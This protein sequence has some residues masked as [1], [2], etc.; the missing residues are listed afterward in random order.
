MKGIAIPLI[1]AGV[2]LPLPVLAL[3]LESGGGPGEFLLLLAVA[4]LC[5]LLWW[6][7]Y[8]WRRASDE[9]TRQ[10][11]ARARLFEILAGAPDGHYRWDLD[12]DGQPI[13]ERCSRRL[14][15]LLDLFGGVG[16]SFTNVLDSFPP[17]AAEK[18]AAA[19][20]ALRA[21]GRGFELELPL[22][23]ASRR[24]LVL[25]GR[26]A[27]E[28]GRAL[29][30]VVWIR[31]VTERS[32]VLDRLALESQTLLNGRDQLRAVFDMLPVPVWIR[33]DDLALRGCNL[34]YA[35]A[36]DA[37][38]PEEAVEQGRELAPAGMVREAR[39]LAARARAAGASRSES[40]HLVMEGA[41]RMAEVI[42]TPLM[43]GGAD[44]LL[45][46]GISIDR[47]RQ[48]EA[49]ALVDRHAVAHAE[50]LENLGTAIAIFAADTRLSFFNTAF[51]KL[52]GLKDEWGETKP[53]YGEVLDFWRET[54]RLPEVADFRDF[55][56]EETRRFTSL[57]EPREDLLHLP[58]ER[59]LRRVISPHP[60]GGLIFTYED[61]TDALALK[62]SYTTS[63]A[64]HGETLDN[65]HEGVAVFG[66]DGRLRLSNPAYGRIWKLESEFL[67][68]H[69]H[70]GELV[71]R[72]RGFFLSATDWSEARNELA[73]LFTSRQGHRGRIERSD[74]SHLDYA[75]LPLPDGSVLTTWLD[76]SD[77]VRVEIALRERNEALAAADKLKSEFLASVS[78]EVR[79]P[80]TTI[81]GH[82]DILASGGCGALNNRQTDYANGITAAG[83]HLEQVFSDIL[84]L[85]AIEAGQ[86]AL[87]LN[88]VDIHAMLAAVLALTRERIREKRLVLTFDCPL[89][90]GWMVADERRIRQVLF[91][92]LSNAIKFTPETG[93][94]A[95]VAMRSSSSEGDEIVFAVSDSGRG[96]AIED[97]ERV[98]GAFMRAAADEAEEP[99][100]GLG[101][102]LVKNFV[103]LHGGYVELESALGEGST[104][105]IHLPS[106]EV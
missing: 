97:R 101:L 65:L 93:R 48:E 79:A 45:T 103:G 15:V 92:L 77:S 71:G 5:V 38:S 43:G 69:P 80:L 102:T 25:G 58:D 83:R 34:A 7:H 76:V 13:G 30:D 89:D 99:G 1:L 51:R 35:Q 33:G 31:D 104:F 74:G 36:V 88:A 95:L 18:L 6:Q 84:D 82:A 60:F 59:T 40:F 106:G 62:R 23:D 16:S 64:V 29:S 96:I 14:A 54:R 50:V 42:E 32:V 94:I 20:E 57:L 61:V 67:Q 100:A 78:A 27:D 2:T 90:I 87:S 52:W 63:L 81:L 47:T 17:D 12:E 73:G 55:R 70:I 46:V 26:A 91:N 68:G 8:L 11:I 86:M 66:S 22:R 28:I 39:A 49:L 72:L 19:V 10:S 98:F 21:E 105:I 4:I 24:V 56:E 53:T 75:S 9:A 44:G 85:A 37:A 41:R 3:A